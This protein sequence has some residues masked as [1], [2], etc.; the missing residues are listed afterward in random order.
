[1][2][3]ATGV[4]EAIIT[5]LSLHSNEAPP[6]AYLDD[7][8]RECTGVRHIVGGSLQGSLRAALSNSF[9]F[10]GSNTVLAFRAVQ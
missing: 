10:G 2:L 1:M 8:D 7:L 9:A 6:T 4:I 3:G 5:V